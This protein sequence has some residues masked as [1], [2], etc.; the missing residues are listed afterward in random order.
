M[1]HDDWVRSV[2][3]SPDGRVLAS[4]SGDGTIKLWMRLTG[5][6]FRTFRGHRQAV[7]RVAFSPTGDYLASVG[8]DHT[9]GIWDPMRSCWSG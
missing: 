4:G 1:K 7:H 5:R 3:Y 8:W 6:E 2:A 9:V